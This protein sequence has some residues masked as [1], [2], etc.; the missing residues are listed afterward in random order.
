MLTARTWADSNVVHLPSTT[1][2]V[3][4]MKTMPTTKEE[5]DVYVCMCVHNLYTLTTQATRPIL[6]FTKMGGGRKR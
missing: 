4:L 2:G 6:E 1:T 5:E 3:P